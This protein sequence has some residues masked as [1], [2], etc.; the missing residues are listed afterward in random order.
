VL[1]LATGM[2]LAEAL[3]LRWADVAPDYDSIRVNY[4]LARAGGDVD[5]RGRRTAR[6]VLDETKTKRRRTVALPPFAGAAL[7]DHY[8]RQLEERIA[9]GQP[10]DEGLVFVATTGRPLNEGWVSHRWPKLA[11]K[12]G[13]AT[14]IHG[15]RHGQTSLLVALKVHPRVISGRVGHAQVAMSM[16]RYAHVVEESDREAADRLQEAISG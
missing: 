1:I 6:Y 4:V 8:A 9:A 15:L 2:R 13:V 3:G 5:D 12:A 16:D 14:T 10:T 11:A 7:R